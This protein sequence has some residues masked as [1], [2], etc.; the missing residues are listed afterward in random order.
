MR[1]SK[2]RRL[3]SIPGEQLADA[4]IRDMMGI[5]AHLQPATKPQPGAQM[6]AETLDAGIEIPWLAADEVYGQDP[7]LRKL[8]EERGAGYVPGV[9]CSFRVTLP[10][11]ARMRAA[12]IPVKVP[13]R[14]WTTTSCG[15]GS[16][17]GR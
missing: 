10:S 3:M 2:A 5:P 4:Y 13:G 1:A 17:G 12:K 7:E 14:A 11:G 15:A 16:K 9:A 8:C 6:L